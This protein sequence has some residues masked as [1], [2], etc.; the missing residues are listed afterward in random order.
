MRYLLL[1]AVDPDASEPPPEDRAAVVEDW[2]TMTAMLQTA[3]VLI[4]G[5][6]LHPSDT[7]TTVRLRQ[8]ERLT[9]D[10]PFAET[11]EMLIGYYLLDV[12][13][14]D[15]ALDWAARMPHIPQGCVEVRPVMTGPASG[16]PPPPMV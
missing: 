2:V 13:D 5:D 1:L 12:D 11:K 6:G 10:G 16:S 15:A 8:G 3:G 4:A 9:T 14:L 7:A